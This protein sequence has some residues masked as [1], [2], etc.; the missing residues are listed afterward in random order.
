M[1]LINLG[2]IEG[3][4]HFIGIGGIGMSALAIILH[5]LGF[6]WLMQEAG[7]LTRLLSRVE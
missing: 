6:I 4:I 3:R 5:H 1:N 2:N 7:L